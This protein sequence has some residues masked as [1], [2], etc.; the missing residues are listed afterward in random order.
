VYGFETDDPHLATAALLVYATWRSRDRARFKVTPDVWAQV[1]RFVKAAAKRSTTLA[2]F[3]DRLKPR[4]ACG[5]I[6]PQAIAVGMAGAVPL[7]SG[8]GGELIELA[9]APTREFGVGVIESADQRAVIDA[10]YRETTY[11]ILLVRTRLEGERVIE[12][13][14]NTALDAIGDSA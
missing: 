8:P 1:E 7:V 10:L 13:R 9:Q 14:L 2:Q 5:T 6:H 3:L 4:L 12:A 11:V